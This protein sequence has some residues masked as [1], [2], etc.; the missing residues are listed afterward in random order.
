MRLLKAAATSVTLMKQQSW[1][2]SLG[3]PTAMS[4]VPLGTINNFKYTLTDPKF[5]GGSRESKCHPLPSPGTTQV[6][7]GTALVA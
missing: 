3:S 1:S 5:T 4:L 6:D 7:K 2:P